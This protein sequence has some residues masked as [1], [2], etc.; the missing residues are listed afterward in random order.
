MDRERPVWALPTLQSVAKGFDMGQKFAAYDTTGAITGFYDAEDSPAPAGATVIEITDAQWQTCITNPGWTVSNGALNAPAALTPAQLLSAAQASQSTLIDAAYYVAIQQNVTFKTA[1][2]VTKTFQAD[3]DSQTL[4]MQ[5]TQ[6]YQIA[7]ATPAGFYWKAA[8]N[9]LVP[10]TLADLQ[11]L[12]TTILAQGWAAFQKR[13]TL[14]A[15][16][17][18]ATNVAAVQAVVWA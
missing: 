5:A 14:K 6:G 17:E 13:T 4:V 10:F 9:T 11:G 18:A 3:A 16:I 7:G 2:G 8:D 15:Q 12:Y 1:A